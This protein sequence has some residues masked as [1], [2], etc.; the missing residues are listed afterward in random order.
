M[1]DE[2]MTDLYTVLCPTD[3]TAAKLFAVPCTVTLNESAKLFSIQWQVL[4]VI[5]GLKETGSQ[6]SEPKPT[7]QVFFSLTKSSQ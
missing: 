2:R 4:S 7:F 1:K 5:P 6:I 3:S